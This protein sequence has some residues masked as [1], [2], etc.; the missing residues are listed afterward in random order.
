VA[1]LLVIEDNE[2]LAGL[3]AQGL[4]PHGYRCDLA[5]TLADA[6]AALALAHFDAIILDLGLPDGDGGNWL[7]ARPQARDIP[8]LILTARDGL[9]DRVDGLDAGADD[10]LVKPFALDELAA[11]LRA[12]LRRPGR[13]AETVLRV[14]PISYDMAAR[15]AR[16]NETPVDLPRRE[17]DLL[18]LLMRRAG[19]VVRRQAMEDA[20]YRFDE[21]VT[22][23][24]MEAIVS[25]LRRKLDDAGA[26]GRLHT[27]RGVGYLLSEE[28]R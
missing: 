13:R 23:N 5:T 1:R 12:M 7:R 20:L 26:T 11:R 9:N 8:T 28:A 18:E 4:S 2:R 3:I 6:D 24:A 22:P 25:R 15:R 17:A 14:G 21:A 27:V 16:V 19:E 10:Y